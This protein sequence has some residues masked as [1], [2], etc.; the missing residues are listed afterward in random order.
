MIFLFIKIYTFWVKL[1][2]SDDFSIKKINKY[3]IYK[4]NRT[5]KKT[6]PF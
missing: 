1:F 6:K 4:V 5:E 3:Y 2:K